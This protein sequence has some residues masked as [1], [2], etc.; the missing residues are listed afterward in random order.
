MQIPADK[1]AWGISPILVSA[2]SLDSHSLVSSLTSRF[3]K[4]DTIQTDYIVYM[5]ELAS[6][7]GAK[8]NILWLFLTDP[9]L[10]LEVYFGPC[11]PYQF[12]LV[13]PG[14][15]PGARH[16]ILTQWDRS[17]KPTTTRAVGNPVKPCLFYS[18]FRPV[19]ISV[20][21]VAIFLLLI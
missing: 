15:W 14:K 18:W 12:R 13:G 3:G 6:F 11:S 20:V 17:L 4:S 5:D 8:P 19:A 9:K 16:A 21:S 2:Q 10:A 1:S 7:I